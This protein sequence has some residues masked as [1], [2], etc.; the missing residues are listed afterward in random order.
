[1]QIDGAKLWISMWRRNIEY[2]SGMMMAT[3]TT[4]ARRM[5]KRFSNF[6]AAHITYVILRIPRFVPQFSFIFLRYRIYKWVIVCL[7]RQR[8][9]HL[10]HNAFQW[11]SDR[12]GQIIRY[13]LHNFLQFRKIPSQCLWVPKRP[14]LI[15]YYLLYWLL[16]C[17][18]LIG[19]KQKVWWCLRSSKWRRD[20]IAKFLKLY[21]FHRIVVK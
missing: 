10:I 9:G 16:W 1:M 19:K 11:C 4:N 21:F 12:V 18:L 8:Y 17:E 7:F 5:L 20:P 13:A 2:N 6:V 15:S 14:E 3:T